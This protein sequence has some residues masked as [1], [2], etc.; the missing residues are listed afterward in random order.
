M[1][2]TT[3][4]KK[5]KAE[6]VSEEVAAMVGAGRAVSLEIVDF[7]N[8]NRP[9][10][11][12][13]V[14]FPILPVNQVAVIEGNAGKPIY[15]VSKWWA[16]RRSSVF[17]SMLI[18]AATKA[19]DDEALAAKTVWDAYYANHQRKGTFSD[20]SVAEIFM[21]GGTTIVE[22]ARLGMKMTGNDL[23]PVAWFVVKGEMAKTDSA[24]IKSLLG[25]IKEE[26][27]PKILPF[28]ATNCPRGHKGRWFEK[29]TGAPVSHDFNPLSIPVSDRMKY[30]YEG[31][32]VIYTFWAK[33]GP[34]SA[35]GCGH[36][37]PVMSSHMVAVKE[38]SVKTWPG[39]RCGCG[40]EFGIEQQNARMAPGAE[41][42]VSSSEG[43]FAAMDSKGRFLCPSC[44]KE[45]QDLKAKLEGSSA[46]L[47]KSINK[48]VSLSLFV[49]P[50]WMKGESSKDAN[51]SPYGGSVEDGVQE[52]GLWNDVRAANLS[53]I[54]VRGAVPSSIILRSGVSFEPSKGNI[55]KRSNFTCRESTCGREQ[56]LLE[57]VK[58][59]GKTAPFAA[60]ADQCYCPECDAKGE[61]YGGRYFDVPN[62]A[63]INAAL[64]EWDVEKNDGLAGYWP[65]SEILVG[66]EIGPHDVNGHHYS[67]WWKMFNGRQLLI[68]SRLLKSILE[69]TSASWETKE[70]VLGGF[71]QYLRNQNLF[72][73]WNPQGDKM[74]PH[75]SK[76]N[77]HPKSTA[78]ENC[79]FPKLGRGNWSSCIEG[80]VESIEWCENPWDLV[81]NENLVSLKPALAKL[82]S[83]KSEKAYLG[84]SPRHDVA[85][86]CGSSTQLSHLTDGS[87][88]LVITD[89][90]FG[91]LVQYAELSDFFYVWL[92][93]ALKDRYPEIFGGEFTPKTLEAV[94]N[95]FREPE[96][97]NGFYKR[98]LTQCWREAHRIMKPG[99]LLAFTFHHSEDEPWVAVLESLFDAGFYLEATYP[100]RSD[101]T[102]GDGDFGSQ[103]VEYDIIHVCRKRQ[104]DPS[105]ISWA[106]LRRGIAED[107]RQLKGILERH[108]AGGLPKADLQVIRRGKALEYFS[109]HYGHVFIEKG[110]DFSLIEALAGIHQL[111]DDENDS[112]EGTPPVLAE[113]LTRQFLR[114]FDGVESVERDQVQKY[115]RGTGTSPALFEDRGW[116]K[117]EKKTYHLCNPLEFAMG[118]KGRQRK[119]MSRDFDQT[120][121]LVGACFPG[122]EIRV[123]E[124]LNN[125]NFEPHPAIPDLLDWMG[126]RAFS[127]EA[128]RAAH[129]AKTLYS[130]WLAD[131][132]AKVDAA[133]AQ[134]DL[135]LEF[136]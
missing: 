125:P 66:A 84:D 121:F 21:G 72:C 27:R 64:A 32:E 7:S 2:R 114:I 14:D 62:P 122:S 130:R 28:Y 45:H 46:L 106:K 88:D 111:L 79:V 115:L 67:H 102:K 110:R 50:E 30:G 124:T 10:T 77:F 132:K 43:L 75:F 68:L 19:P 83:G 20:V 1:A 87:V 39:F 36:R 63:R 13:E 6:I 136:A 86:S 37:S 117:E 116:C 91:D 89:P 31:P 134:F 81:A 16:R 78:I 80:I 109:K 96:N 29:T 70:S 59:F 69:N 51:G 35:S 40:T 25:E 126:R 74:E 120:L 71:Q 26:V 18:A 48:K 100:I 42:V 129:T 5:N 90:P 73:F 57:S 12:I 112:G 11:C 107:V 55:P 113:P 56:D 52:T 133:T 41:F 118:W 58:G 128:R 54:E 61:S 97:P 65:Q 135:P 53:L 15:Q 17:R 103:K 105:P 108:S 49:H 23:N 95:R 98:L 92:R 9:K 3:T 82:I 94:A 123:E 127:P 101:E 60:Y 99:G 38:I 85:L 33:H 34:C 22:G 131:H 44:G 47:A 93:L 119:G 4:G 8:P 76:S 104:E 24:E